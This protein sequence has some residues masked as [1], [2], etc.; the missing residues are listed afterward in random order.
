MSLDPPAKILIIRRDNIGDLV[1]TTPL[2]SAL[3]QRFPHGWLGAL[4]NSYNAPVLEGNP[5][6]DEVFVYTKAK[7]RSAGESLAA[8]LWRRLKMMRQLHAMQLDDVIIATT[9]PQPRVVKLAQW[10]KPKRI[11]GFGDVKGLDLALPLDDAARHEVEDVFRVAS[12]YGIDGPPPACRVMAPAG[13]ARAAGLTIGI[14]ISARKPSQR[15][16]A[17]HFAE[18]IKVLAAQ[19]SLRFMLLWSPGDSENP[20]H[21]G[22]DAKAS[23]VLARVGAGTTATLAVEARPTQTLPELIG[24]LAECDSL[25]CADGGAMHLAAGLGLPI[26]CLFGNS[27]AA[28]WRPWG[29][30]YRLLQKPSLNVSDIGVN[31]VVG[32][33]ASLNVSRPTP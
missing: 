11:I 27:G 24:A 21:P 30:P 20:L 3:R 29:V 9:S 15:W 16:P 7:H 8:I 17:D 33:F 13:S 1:C 10:L 31:E 28:R 22:D 19:G 18:T 2:I 23:E 5:D 26:V 25:I 12:L 4:V 14:H 6:L 32:A